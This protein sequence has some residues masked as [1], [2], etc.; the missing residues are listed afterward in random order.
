MA[1]DTN[2]E[3]PHNI[4]SPA[5]KYK[6]KSHKSAFAYF[7]STGTLYSAHETNI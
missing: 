4:I 3:S 7:V 2:Y 6:N 5:L 1:K